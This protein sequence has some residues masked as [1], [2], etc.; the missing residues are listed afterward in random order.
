MKKKSTYYS[1]EEIKKKLAR[2]CAYRDRSTYEVE[3]KLD[4]YGAIPE[5]K[6]R[7]LAFLMEENFLDDERFAR[8]FARGKF[9]I[10]S[11]GRRKIGEV[12]R[13]HQLSDYYIEKA[14]EEIDENEYSEK[15]RYLIRKK[16]R[17]T[18][19]STPWEAK[20]KIYRYLLQKGY[21]PG[22]FSDPLHD[23]VKRYFAT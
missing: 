15:I 12:L 14:M 10:K 4:E 11:W 2:Y 8:S 16:L 18:R 3:K 1:P 23:E 6:D 7:I 13:R 9:R 21:M 19:F 17:E 5:V 22:E 20:R